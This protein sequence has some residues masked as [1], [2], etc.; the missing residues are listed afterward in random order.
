MERNTAERNLWALAHAL[1]KEAH[2]TL[3][4]DPENGTAPFGAEEDAAGTPGLLLARERGRTVQVIRLAAV[5]SDAHRLAQDVDAFRLA[6][7]RLR[8]E[9]DRS[10]LEG[11]L[12]YLAP[13]GVDAP[14]ARAV[15]A[16]NE[17][18]PVPDLEIACD[19]LDGQ[20]G[21]WIAPRPALRRLGLK[22]EWLAEMARSPLQPPDAYRAAIRTIEA[23]RERELRQT[24][25]YGRPFFVSLFAVLNIALF[26]GMEIAGS[27][28]DAETLIRFG[29]KE[30]GRILQGE[31]WRLI[32]A[33]FLH[34]GLIHLLVNTVALLFVGGAVE[35]IFGR[36]RFF[37]VYVAAGVAGTAASFA[38]TPA[39]SAGASG[40]IFGLM[41]AL[42]YFGTRRRRLFVRTM[43]RDL[44]FYLLLNLLLGLVLPSVDHYGHL[45]GLLGGFLA[46]G[47]VG[48]PGERR[49]SARLGFAL[50]WGMLV[51]GALRLGGL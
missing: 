41:G 36:W 9:W 30:N 22:P 35:R 47:A 51:V 45:G 13:D 37:A 32:T 3:V 8:R 40:A 34:V 26:A 16:E 7:D 10:R 42:L 5:P 6:A 18:E 38:F 43:G 20:T 46:A 12:L 1:V 28:T 4:N 27:S 17:K 49:L 31:G 23:E 25:G 21:A 24:F 39:L 29:A 11:L 48:L 2:Y 44:L 19:L 50:A 33:M 14:L 15:E